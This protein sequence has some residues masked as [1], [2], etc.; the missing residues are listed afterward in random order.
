MGDK[1]TGKRQGEKSVGNLKYHIDKTG[2]A[3]RKTPKSATNDGNL[4]DVEIEI[5]MNMLKF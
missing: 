2:G 4:F 3:G 1:G 5:Q